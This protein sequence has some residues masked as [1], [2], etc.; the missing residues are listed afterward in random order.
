MSSLGMGE[1]R[2]GGR[3]EVTFVWQTFGLPPCVWRH[4]RRTSDRT[5]CSGFGARKVCARWQPTEEGKKGIFGYSLGVIG[6]L[7]ESTR[8]QEPDKRLTFGLGGVFSTLSVCALT[9]GAWAVFAGLAPVRAHEKMIFLS[10]ESA[11]FGVMC[12][13]CVVSLASQ[14]RC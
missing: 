2:V 6:I 8:L 1:R 11:R 10:F 3:G 13:F 9:S 5:V 4:R 7:N 12:I 14:Y